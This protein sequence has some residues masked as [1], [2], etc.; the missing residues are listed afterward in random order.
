MP[1]RRSTRSCHAA[2]LAC[3]PAMATS[4]SAP[5]AVWNRAVS[6]SLSL[7]IVPVMALTMLE[8]LPVSRPHAILSHMLRPRRPAPC[9]FGHDADADQPICAVGAEDALNGRI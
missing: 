5:T 9:K 3:I 1:F 8:R 2:A 6:L 7:P 4:L